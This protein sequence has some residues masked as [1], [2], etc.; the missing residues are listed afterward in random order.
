MERELDTRRFGRSLCRRHPTAESDADA[1]TNA[2]TESD[3][4]ANPRSIANTDSHADANPRGSFDTEDP[5]R[6]PVANDHV[7]ADAC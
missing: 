4:D 3:A 1:N 2:I 5:D 7:G 6:Q